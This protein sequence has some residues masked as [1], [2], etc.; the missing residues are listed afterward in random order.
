MTR[1]VATAV[2]VVLAAIVVVGGAVALAS[3]DGLEPPEVPAEGVGPSEVELSPDAAADPDGEAVRAQLQRHY[4]AI[5]G[6]D[7]ELW[8]TTVV[9]E[10]AEAL[11]EEEWLEA[12][13]TTRDG[14]IRV[15]RI[16]RD[17]DGTLL[18]RV[19]FISSQAVEKAPPDLPATRICWRSTLPMRG[20][21]PL[22]DLTGGGSSARER[23]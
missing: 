21:P 14:S 9:P 2:G 7:Y 4:D 10:R 15:D 3:R 8:R 18:V 6:R 22:I 23:C 11:G 20:T 5:N 13:A 19:R 16:D 17:P 12:Y 1:T